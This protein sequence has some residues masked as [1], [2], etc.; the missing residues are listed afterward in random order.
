MINRIALVGL[1]VYFAYLAQSVTFAWQRIVQVVPDI[2]DECCTENCTVDECYSFT[3]LIRN[4]VGGSNLKVAFLP[5]IHIANH[6]ASF[7]FITGEYSVFD[8]INFTLSADNLSVGA[9]IL[10][11]GTFGFSFYNVTNLEI[12]GLTFENCGEAILVPRP[13]HPNLYYTLYIKRTANVIITNVTVKYGRGIGLNVEQPHGFFTLS[14]TTVMFKE[15]NFYFSTV[16]INKSTNLTITDSVFTHGLRGSDEYSGIRLRLL[17]AYFNVAINMTNVSVDNNDESNL[18]VEYNVCRT[19]MN[20]ANLSSSNSK[21]GLII[22]TKT[23]LTQCNG[24]NEWGIVSLTNA[25]FMNTRIR[26]ANRE[27][28]FDSIPVQDMVRYQIILSNIIVLGGSDTNEFDNVHGVILRQIM[29]ERSGGIRIINVTMQI[30]GHFLYKNNDAAVVILTSFDNSETGTVVTLGHHTTAIF[31]DNVVTNGY[32]SPLHITGSTINLD[33]DAH[34][35][36]TNN[37]GLIC[38][39]MLLYNTVVRFLFGINS[40]RF[41]HNRGSTGGAMALYDRS[42]LDFR[43]AFSTLNFTGNHA[44]DVGGAI[45]VFDSGYFERQYI[46]LSFYSVYRLCRFRTIP[47]FNFANNTAQ[48]A[49]SALYGGWVDSQTYFIYQITFYN[50]LTHLVNDAE[51]PSLISSDPTRVCMCVHSTPNCTITEIAA[52][53]YPGQMYM[54]SVVAVGQRFGTVPS[55]IQT[56]FEGTVKSTGEIDEIQ[57]TQGLSH[58]CTNVSFTVRSSAKQERLSLK[59]SMQNHQANTLRNYLTAGN[60]QLLFETFEILFNLRGCP[61]GFYFETESKQCS[62][63]KDVLDHDIECNSS[64]FR[65]LRPTP[66]WINATFAHLTENQ[67]SGVL[68]H[69]HCPFDYCILTEGD[70]LPLDLEYPDEQCA[71]NRSGI[72][73]GACHSYF[74]HVLG[75]SNCKKCSIPW[76]A[77]IVPMIVLAG[78]V[79]VAFLIILNLTVSVGSISGLIFYAN[80]VRANNAAFFPPGVNNSSLGRFSSFLNTFIAWLNLDLGIEVCLYDG[81][82]AYIKTWL[83]FIFPL[84]IW[85]LVT[86]IIIASHYSTTASRLSGNN[87]VQVLAT[88]F[89]L[90]YAKLLRLIITIFSYTKLVYP[91]SYSRRVWLY[92]GNVDYLQGKHIPLFIAALALLLFVSIPYTATLFFIQWLQRWSSFKVFFWVRKLHPLFDA[93]TG[94]FKVKHRYWTGLLLLV[95]VCLFLIF[96]LNSLGDPTINLLAIVAVSFCVLTYISLVGGIYKLWY[97][98][99]LENAFILNLGILSAGVGFYQD[100]TSTVVPAI[101]C[102]SVGISFML[103]AVIVF[104]H[105]VLKALKSRRGRTLNDTIQSKFLK[106]EGKEDE[107]ELKKSGVGE[108]SELKQLTAVAVTQSVVDV[109]LSEP[110]LTPP[111][112]S[113]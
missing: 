62:C 49:G 15:Q 74:S 77:L 36:F 85:L 82:T 9:T 100:N 88:L 68:V 58:W 110:L 64:S 56:Q 103:F 89:L 109:S 30:E 39:G 94:P 52:D 111:A 33:N 4:R 112:S 73:C 48:F 55:I 105:L 104:C 102:T 65:V 86:V 10:C 18:Y 92:D 60:Q 97:L 107:A 19:S 81:L 51:H 101:T 3:E 98:N 37:S 32:Q 69:N 53:L 40:M 99:L 84:Y 66:K 21:T 50:V 42:L 16:Q 47:K 12:S 7:V 31:Q 71:F 6:D 108:G 43:C 93:Y 61:L 67:S 27:S 91:D 75:T 41:S 76:V 79:L 14:K 80:I 5:G 96:S 57:Q 106:T 28:S 90:S 20:I 54:L 17:H 34:M 87:A 63:Q 11:N 25:M 59:N 1:T 95:R 2:P 45:Y 44:T 70:L 22:V 23:S 78:M 24:I 8:A 29:F 13:G 38:G 46:F 26:V 35:V 113:K 83:Q 72:L